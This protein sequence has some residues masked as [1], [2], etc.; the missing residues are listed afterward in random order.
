[1]KQLLLTFIATNFLL[2]SF[3]Q[4]LKIT[5][6]QKIYQAEND[7]AESILLRKKFEFVSSEQPD[8]SNNFAT[9]LTYGYNISLNR[10]RAEKFLIIRS[11]LFGKIVGYT[12]KKTDEYQAVRDYCKKNDFKMA[13]SSQEKNSLQYIYV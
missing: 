9:T 4:N 5:D 8:S 10:T 7:D 11:S 1:M 2:I 12:T 13:E 6:L 3:C